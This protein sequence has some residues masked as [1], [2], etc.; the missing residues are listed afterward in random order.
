[1]SIS[2]LS[3]LFQMRTI[4]DQEEMSLVNLPAIKPGGGSAPREP[5]RPVLGG[6]C[7][8][9]HGHGSFSSYRRQPRLPQS[10]TREKRRLQGPYIAHYL[11]STGGSSCDCGSSNARRSTDRRRHV[12]RSNSNKKETVQERVREKEGAVSERE[13]THECSERHSTQER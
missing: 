2:N 8:C 5:Q 7:Y 12:F 4:K 11:M 3:D 9:I 10:T 6:Y 1:M 13:K